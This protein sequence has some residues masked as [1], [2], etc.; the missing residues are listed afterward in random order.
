MGLGVHDEAAFLA[1]QA[2]H[3]SGVQVDLAGAGHYCALERHGESLFGIYRLACAFTGVDATVPDLVAAGHFGSGQ[4]C[5][6]VHATAH[7]QVGAVV[8][9]AHTVGAQA[10][11]DGVQ[12]P[13]QAGVEAGCFFFFQSQRRG[14]GWCGYALAQLFLCKLFVKTARAG[15]AFQ[16]LLGLGAGTF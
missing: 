3:I 8:P 6:V 11:V 14:F 5:A 9:L 10:H 2:V 7:V 15:N 13:I 16:Q 1:D 12:R 4:K